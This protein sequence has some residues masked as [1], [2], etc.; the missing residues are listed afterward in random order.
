MILL[1][2][3]VMVVFTVLTPQ[4]AFSAPATTIDELAKMYSIEK[5]AE[6]HK[7]L[8][9]IHSEWK[10][11]WHAKSLIDSRVIRVWRTFIL[12]GLDKDGLPR[13]ELKGAC[14]K[15][16]APQI[17]NATDEVAVKIAELVVTAAD[18]K[19]AAKRDAAI[20]EL[21]KVNI[22][23]LICHNMKATPDGKPE[24]GAVYGPKGP[25]KIDPTPHEE[26]KIKS[27]KSDFLK[28]SE[29]CAQCHHGCDPSI[30][31][32]MC[33]TLF[34]NY[35]EHYIKQGGT[36]T[37]QDCHM[38]GTDYKSHKFPGI[39]DVDFAKTGIELTLNASPTQYVYHLENKIVPAAIVN[40]QLKNTAGHG[41]PHGCV[42]I[43]SASLDVT[44]K[45]QNGKVI[46][47]KSKE[48]IVNDFYVKAVDPQ[49]KNPI[50]LA[51][52]WFDRQVHLHEGI[53][54]GEV[55]SITFV[56]PLEVGTKSVNVEAAF[57][58]VYEKGKEA[59]WNSV[60]KKVEF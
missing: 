26:E 10:D 22:N 17:D 24:A 32:E 15:C 51:N 48:Y 53:D 36:K 55:D 42:Y 2:A 58:F 4:P 9:D 59:V 13:K 50:V 40:I 6:C 28:T 34:T 18:D 20:K 30:S 7:D 57:K 29:F 33:P 46:Y 45:D 27:I 14:L 49:A 12:N 41:I 31:S 43:P 37:C 54:P 60:S 39:M 3:F 47:T 25:E 35:K 52:W 38:Q 1:L 8:N 19:D 23:C 56:I 44:V 16:H 11:S 21:S 5:C